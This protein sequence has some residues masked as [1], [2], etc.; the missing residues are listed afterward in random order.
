MFK[1]SFTSVSITALFIA[2]CVSL[3]NRFSLVHKMQRGS[4]QAYLSTNSEHLHSPAVEL[5][6]RYLT[7]N[8]FS[9]LGFEIITNYNL[10]QH[11][12]VR[13]KPVNTHSAATSQSSNN[14]N[15]FF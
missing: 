15:N 12:P 6:A 2:F 3:N 7:S 14:N 5:A 13:L 1:M 9:V 8:S 11:H 4:E 10:S